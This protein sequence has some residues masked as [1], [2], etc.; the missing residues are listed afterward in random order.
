MSLSFLKPD[1]MVRYIHKSVT[2]A[3]LQPGYGADFYRGGERPAGA[4]R[5]SGGGGEAA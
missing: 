3:E 4:P 5:T 2:P 1:P